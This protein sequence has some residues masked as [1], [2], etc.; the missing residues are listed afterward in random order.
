MA[1]HPATDW[2][3]AATDLLDTLSR[4]PMPS[5]EGVVKLDLEPV[6]LDLSTIPLEDVLK[7]R[8]D[9]QVA[10]KAYMRSLRGFLVELGR[11]SDPA[12]RESALLE[13][14]QEIADLAHDNRRSVGL[15]VGKNLG[16]WSLGIAGGVWSALGGDIL[17]ATL[18]VLGLGPDLVPGGREKTVG[19]Y[20]YL[21][22]VTSAFGRRADW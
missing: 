15:S 22:A 14:R 10:H 2:P 1:V 17:G 13:R 6:A 5:C 3:E 18:G 8:E 11:I 20:S 7:L 12:E 9:H 16:S 21:F 4:E 19:A